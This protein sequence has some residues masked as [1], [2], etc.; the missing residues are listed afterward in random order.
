MKAIASSLPSFMR[1]NEGSKGLFVSSVLWEICNCWYNQR[2]RDGSVE[3]NRT[4]TR[5]RSRRSDFRT[6][7]RTWK[8]ELQKK[9]YFSFFTY[10]FMIKRI[11]IYIQNDIVFCKINL[12]L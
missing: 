9:E 2:R 8:T 10:D 4:G 1:D 11:Y 6:L 3:Q 7:I 12:I 5:L